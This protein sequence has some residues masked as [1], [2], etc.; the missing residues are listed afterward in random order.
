MMRSIL[1]SSRFHSKVILIF[2]VTPNTYQRPYSMLLIGS[3]KHS[4]I[5]ELS[6]NTKCQDVLVR[7]TQGHNG[8]RSDAPELMLNTNM[9]CSRAYAQHFQIIFSYVPK[10]YAQHKCKYSCAPEPLTQHTCKYSCSLESL[11]QHKTPHRSCASGSTPNTTF[12][13]SCASG[14]T[15]NTTNIYIYIYISSTIG[16][17]PI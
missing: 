16:L 10:L 13:Q 3:Y 7:Y 12:L 5:P 4:A 15:P 11:A 14:S 1:F 9:E 17:H 2:S 8:Q 6:L